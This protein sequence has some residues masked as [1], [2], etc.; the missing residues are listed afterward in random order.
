MVSNII[1]KV[2]RQVLDTLRT[3]E[4]QT[5]F[6]PVNPHWNRKL[7]NPG[8]GRYYKNLRVIVRSYEKDPVYVISARADTIT[9]GEGH[10][11]IRLAE[12]RTLL[13][14]FNHQFI[15]ETRR[16]SIR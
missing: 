13:P 9:V 12:I 15:N 3:G 6:L 8:T 11:I 5:V 1:V 16:N 2:N 14:P 10:Y 4:R 7:K